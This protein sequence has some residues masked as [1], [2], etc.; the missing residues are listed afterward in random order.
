MLVFIEKTW[1]LW[2]MLAMVAGIR[3]FHLISVNSKV[4]GFEAP[5]PEEEEQAYIVSWRILRNAQPV[6]LVETNRAY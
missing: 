5:A 4:E 3:W 2:W 1:F 6:S